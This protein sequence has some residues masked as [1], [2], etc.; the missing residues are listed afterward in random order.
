MSRYVRS[1]AGWSSA[2]C[3][4]LLAVVKKKKVESNVTATCTVIQ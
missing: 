3:L 1:L 4:P 2:G